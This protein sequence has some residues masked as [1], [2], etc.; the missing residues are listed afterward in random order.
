MQNRDKK[1]AYHIAAKAHNQIACPYSDCM[2]IPDV[3]GKTENGPNSVALISL[4]CCGV[5]ACS[6]TVAI[7]L[8]LISFNVPQ[9]MCLQHQTT[10]RAAEER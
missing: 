1:T 5:I 6:F 3:N 9:G 8:R 7:W 4:L 10:K 2:F